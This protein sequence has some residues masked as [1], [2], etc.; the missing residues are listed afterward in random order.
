MAIDYIG[1][2]VH[3]KF[4]VSR[5]KGYRDIRRADFRVERT[6]MTEDYHIRQK[7]LTGVSRLK[8]VENVASEANFSGTPSSRSSSLSVIETAEGGRR[9]G[10]TNMSHRNN[11]ETA[12]YKYT[13][14][15]K[16]LWS[17][18]YY[19]LFIHYTV[20]FYSQ[21]IAGIPRSK[22]ALAPPFICLY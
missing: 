13:A 18:S 3:A 5:S 6:N 1:V 21:Q 14:A 16:R 22:G 7:R 15:I 11:L 4:C 8:T 2:D 20:L 17:H 12:R 19:R 9:V 10:G